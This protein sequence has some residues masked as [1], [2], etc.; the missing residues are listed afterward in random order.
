[1]KTADDI[2]GMKGKEKIAML[3]CYDA[4]S[5]G[6]M[7]GSVDLILV[8]DSLGMVMLGYESTLKVTMEDMLRAIG[9]V[10]RG[11]R[12]TLIVGDM[13]LGTYDGRNDALRN[14]KAMLAVGAHAV[15]IE[16]KPEMA[17]FLAKQGITV[18]GHIGLT[19]QTATDFKVKGK[20]EGDAQKLL[21]EARDM[22]EA[23]CFSLV[24]ECIPLELAK[25]ISDSVKIPTIGIGAGM[26]CDGQVLVMHDMLGLYRKLSP[27]FVKRYAQL[28]EEMKKAFA[29]YTN[30]VKSGQFPDDV[31][32]FH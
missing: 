5:A 20:N 11:A 26:H 31:H 30:E 32:S 8:G 27:K 16:R 14:A 2:R 7:D 13:P 23:G 24:L 3:T 25:K 9:S 19:P 1:M 18:M 6:L 21:D 15:K 4:S 10:A 29:Q 22:E 12:N 17:A 28:G